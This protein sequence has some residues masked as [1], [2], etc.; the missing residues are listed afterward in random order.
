MRELPPGALKVSYTSLTTLRDCPLKHAWHYRLGYREIQKDPRLDLGSAW[1]EAVLE[2]HYTVIKDY[3]DH[4]LDGRSPERGSADEQALLSVAR[5]T[6]EAALTAALTEGTYG[7]LTVEDYD[8]L[9]WMY[10]GYTA[11]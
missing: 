11:H 4:T 6:V 5:D 7:T 9:R 8:T 2:P 10:D 1:H 3:Q